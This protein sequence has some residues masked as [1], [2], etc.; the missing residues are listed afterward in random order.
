MKQELEIFK[1]AVIKAET[2]GKLA[3]KTA[4]ESKKASDISLP[5]PPNIPFFIM[6]SPDWRLY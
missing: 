1:E 6:R 4:D 5:S 3:Q 2:A